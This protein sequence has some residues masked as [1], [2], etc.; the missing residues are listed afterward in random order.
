MEKEIVW[1]RDNYLQLDLGFNLVF[2]LNFIVRVGHSCFLAIQIDS[3]TSRF[4][5]TFGCHIIIS[6]IRKKSV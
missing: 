5:C 3:F 2:F 4:W 1:L 6:K